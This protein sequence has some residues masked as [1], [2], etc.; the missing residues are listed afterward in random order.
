MSA[1]YLAIPDA[2]VLQCSAARP[3]VAAI[4]NLVFLSTPPNGLTKVLKFDI[5]AFAD[6]TPA[7]RDVILVKLKSPRAKIDA[8]PK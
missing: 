3:D 5:M 4:F 1:E 2:S 6:G 7:K 8:E